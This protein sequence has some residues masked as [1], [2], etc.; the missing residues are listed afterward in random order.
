MAD[1]VVNKIMGGNE[2][3]DLQMPKQESNVEVV[4]KVAAEQLFSRADIELKTDINTNQINALS[5]GLLFGEKYNC[6]LMTDLCNKIM[7]LSVSK[8][9][10]SRGEFTDISK[11][12]ATDIDLDTNT[13]K[14]K[15]RLGL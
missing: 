11:A 7:L 1:P 13:P 8:N 3:Q 6:Q 10:K 12:R 5:R 4:M 2:I 9:R 15:D 14:M